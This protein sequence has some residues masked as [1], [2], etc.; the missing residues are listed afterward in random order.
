MQP[1]PSEFNWDLAL[2]T[3][4]FQ[5]PDKPSSAKRMVR[6]LEKLIKEGD[7]RVHDSGS[8]V[9][10]ILGPLPI[11]A[12]LLGAGGLE[13]FLSDLAAAA[14]LMN[15]QIVLRTRFG[16]GRTPETRGIPLLELEHV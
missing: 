5:G 1:A 12:G 3:V 13:A 16:D 7:L 11:L 2:C 10:P 14:D 9:S 6:R 15:C 4:S 8:G